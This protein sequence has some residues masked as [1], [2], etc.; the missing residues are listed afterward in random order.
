MP[1]TATTRSIGSGSRGPGVDSNMFGRIMAPLSQSEKFDAAGYIREFVPELA[2]VPTAA[3]HDPEEAGC[4]PDDYPAKIIAHR[5][6]RERAL[7]AVK[8]GSLTLREGL[9]YLAPLRHGAAMNAGGQIDR[10]RTGKGALRARACADLPPPA[11]PH[12]HRPSRRRHRRAAAR[13]H[14]PRLLGRA[15]ARAPSRSSP[16]T[17]GARWSGSRPRVRSAGTK[18]GRRATGPAPIRCRCSTCSCATAC[19]WAVRRGQGA[20]SASCCAAGTPCAATVARARAA[21]SP[22]ITTSATISTAN[23]STPG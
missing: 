15:Q 14:A 13:R 6:A 1:I 17:A 9:S 5:E 2:D 3:I 7:E 8:A 18:A 12:R 21:T 23:G 4:R 22:T 11:R 20:G 16:S 19:R 10:K